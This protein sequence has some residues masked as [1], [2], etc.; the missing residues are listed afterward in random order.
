MNKGRQIILGSFD[1]FSFYLLMLLGALGLA[2]FP[3]IRHFIWPAITPWWLQSIAWT[4][5]DLSSIRY[6]GIYFR[7]N[8]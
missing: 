4:S 3:S 8:Q 1:F 2:G 5:D 7:V 6:S